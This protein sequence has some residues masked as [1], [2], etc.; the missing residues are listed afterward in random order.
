LSSISL[1]VIA[2]KDALK[3]VP[4]NIF[5]DCLLLGWYM[6]WSNRLRHLLSMKVGCLSQYQVYSCQIK[7]DSIRLKQQVMLIYID[8]VSVDRLLILIGIITVSKERK[9]KDSIRSWLPQ[10]QRG[11]NWLPKTLILQCSESRV[12]GWM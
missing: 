1:L 6:A 3:D 5:V 2:L 7:D 9:A 12:T 11:P 10:R 8:F 4:F